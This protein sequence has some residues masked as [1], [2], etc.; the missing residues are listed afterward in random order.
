MRGVGRLKQLPLEWWLLLVAAALP[1]TDAVLPRGL[2]VAELFPQIF[3]FAILGLG[4]NCIS[5][6]TGLLNLGVAAFTAIGAYVYGILTCDIYP[7]Q[8]DF[9]SAA[10][11]AL[12]FGG[13][14]GAVL[15]LPALRLHGDYLAIVTLGFGEIVQDLL[16]NLETITKGTQGI[17]PLP[18]PTLVGI[19]GGVEY[20]VPYYTVLFVLVLLVFVSKNL[21]RSQVGRAWMAIRDDEL[22]ARCIGISP[23]RIK[24]GAFTFGAALCALSGALMAAYLGSTGEPGNYDFQLSVIV[25]CIVMVGGLGSIPGVLVGAVVMVGFNSIVLAKLTGWLG[26]IGLADGQN[27]YSMPANWKYFIFGLA[28]IAIARFRP[29]GLVPR[30]GRGGFD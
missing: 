29:L 5:G 20:Y 19:S 28:L 16:R 4:L 2:R 25:L 10:V 11:T 6:Y 1:A 8:L 9:V 15:G 18:P 26:R 23:V 7:F 12:F 17:N 14:A 13:F 24:L 27:V 22:S 30:D 21:E 3:L